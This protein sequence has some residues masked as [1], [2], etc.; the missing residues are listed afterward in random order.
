MENNNGFFNA[1]VS[2]KVNNESENTEDIFGQFVGEWEFDW[3]GYVPDMEVQ[4]EKGEWIFSDISDNSFRWKNIISYN[5][6][7]TWELVQEMNV[8]RKL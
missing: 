1:L 8:K 2:N 4:H 5:H 7:K 6:G 3:F